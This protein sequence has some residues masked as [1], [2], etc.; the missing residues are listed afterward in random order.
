LHEYA[1]YIL[2]IDRSKEIMYDLQWLENQSDWLAANNLLSGDLFDGVKYFQSKNASHV[3]IVMDTR[4]PSL[5][6]LANEIQ[7]KR[8]DVFETILYD[9][10]IAIF[11]IDVE[12]VAA[13]L[14]KIILSA[15][16]Y[17]NANGRI[18]QEPLKYSR[19]EE[20]PHFSLLLKGATNYNISN[21][22][23]FLIFKSISPSPEKLIGD[24]NNFIYFEGI[25]EKEYTLEFVAIYP[26]LNICWKDDSFV[27]WNQDKGVTFRTTGGIASIY[28]EK[29]Y[30]GIYQIVNLNVSQCRYLILRYKVD[31]GWMEIYFIKPDFSSTSV[32]VSG[33]RDWS[34]KIVNLYDLGIKGN[35]MAIKIQGDHVPTKFDLDF[36]LFASAPP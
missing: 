14:D 31:Q 23:K 35:I 25:P 10:D 8:A 22:P 17:V 6:E 9:E 34:T 27:G 5:R 3:Y 4:V 32:L 15:Y 1:S 12:R 28:V 29:I 24:I 16:V 19:F 2:S 20:F 33:S 7:V 18:Y 11:R 21:I 36:I 30:A 26:Y 13:D